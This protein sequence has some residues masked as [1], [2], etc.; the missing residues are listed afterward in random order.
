MRSLVIGLEEVSKAIRFWEAALDYPL[1]E[2]PTVDTQPLP[3]PRSGRG[4]MLSLMTSVAPAQEHPRI[5]Q[6]L[7]ADHWAAETSRLV[8]P[9]ATQS[10][11]IPLAPTPTS[12]S[13]PKRTGVDSA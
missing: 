7:F 3:V 9:E 1:D 5:V 6:D 2:E 8:S 12:R 13:S 10:V 11:G 4:G